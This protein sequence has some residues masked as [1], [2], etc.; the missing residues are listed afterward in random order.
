MASRSRANSI[1]E[2]NWRP[3]A[4]LYR[5]SVEALAPAFAGRPVFPDLGAA[6]PLCIGR[7][8]SEDVIRDPMGETDDGGLAVLYGNIALDGC[9]VKTA[10]VD[11][12]ILKFAGPA[13]VFESQDD[14][15]SA[16]QPQPERDVIE[17]LGGVGDEG[18][19]GRRDAQPRREP[20]ADA[21]RHRQPL[22]PGVVA[23][24]LHLV[25]EAG[26]GRTVTLPRQPHGGGVEIHALPQMGVGI[27]QGAGRRGQ[28]L[29]Y[30]AEGG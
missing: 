12:S 27:A 19:V 28:G 22:G 2:L 30:R 25:V 4:A 9:I 17:R 8:D 23:A 13:R 11:E 10:G 3:A 5:Q 29:R 18:H 6:F 20:L 7:E 24:A 26:H 16:R 15:V 14:A 21:A 1:L